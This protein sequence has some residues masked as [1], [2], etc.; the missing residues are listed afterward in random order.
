MQ[1]ER[2]YLEV[3]EKIRDACNRVD[4]NPD[5]INIIA[6]SKLVSFSKMMDLNKLGQIDFGENR[7]K[8]LREKHYN[9]SLQMSGIVKW[10]LIGHLQ[11]NKVE[12]V[13]AFI[14]LIHSLD[15]LRLAEEIDRKAKKINRI[16]DVL[17]Q[18]NTSNETQKYGIQPDEAS[19][20]CS[21]ISSFDNVRV[22]GLMTIAKL[23]DDKENIRSSFRVLKNLYDEIK[24]AMKDFE[25]LSM[26]MSNDYE[27][28]VEEGS[29]MVRIGSAIFG[30]RI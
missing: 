6:V 26:G 18:V 22:K 23:T 5:E 14:Y 1:L 10:H 27:I 9:I 7:V 4:R 19:E 30:E 25:Y 21:Q 11:S 8:E 2:N 16:I 12:D 13:I 20:L 24:P 3:K 15:N 29:N 28:A 17:I